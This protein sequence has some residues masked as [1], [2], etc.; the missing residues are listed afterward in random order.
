MKSALSISFCLLLLSGLTGCNTQKKY[1]QKDYSF[2]NR[3]FHPDP[4][5]LLRSDGVYV[6]E[7]IWTNE[8]G[9]KERI[10]A[11]RK[12]YKFYKGGQAN[13]ILD[14]D[15]SVEMTTDYTKA[16]NAHIRE[17]TA[18]K[19][20]TLFERYYKYE[21][22][23][24]VIQAVST[25]RNQFYYEYALLEKDGLIIVKSTNQGKGEIKDKYYTDYYKEYY[26]FVPTGESG[27]LEPN[28]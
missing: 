2:Y 22:N 6:Q 28:W 17:S 20:R 11:E 19:Q 21:G 25:P 5:S 18:K 1:L 4:A 15:R 14:P 3:D 23:K 12:I 27:Y 9:G 7:K 16:F 24:M 8:T 10:P 13:I 26:R